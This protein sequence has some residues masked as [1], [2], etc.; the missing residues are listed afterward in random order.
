[1]KHLSRRGFIKSSVTGAVGLTLLPMLQGFKFSPNNTVRIGFIGLG[2][3]AVNCLM[4]FKNIA[5]VQIVG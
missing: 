4:V 5:G 3:Q 2:Q 1:M